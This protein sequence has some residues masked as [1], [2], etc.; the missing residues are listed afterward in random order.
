MMK[1]RMHTKNKGQ[2]LVIVVLMLIGLVG[3][4]ALVLDGGSLFT[5]RRTAQLAAD[6]GALAGARAYCLTINSSPGGAVSAAENAAIQYVGLNDADLVD[7]TVEAGSGDVTVDTS[8][9][10][11]TFFLGILGRSQMTAPAS[12]TAGCTPP[13]E[14]RSVL[15]VAWSCRYAFGEEGVP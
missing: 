13:T 1:T 15:P 6:A 9:T 2:V 4:L 12:A 11:D 5:H 14:G 7:V 10:Y 8:I 3:M